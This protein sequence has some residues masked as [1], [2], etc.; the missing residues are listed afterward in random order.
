[1]HRSSA[2]FVT[3]VASVMRILYIS[4]SDRDALDDLHTPCRITDSTSDAGMAQRLNVDT[5]KTL[6]LA[7]PSGSLCV[8]LA[9]NC[10]LRL[11]SSE[12]ES[13]KQVHLPMSLSTIPARITLPS[14]SAYHEIQTTY[15]NAVP[16]RIHPLC[17][18]AALDF[19]AHSRRY[20]P[21]QRRT[22]SVNH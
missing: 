12:I 19:S 14:C 11:K 1:M 9:P 4:E 3:T 5:T 6:S 18:A 20:F 7:F 2:S 8:V 13:L 21:Y 17:I 16:R 10:S 15:L 22:S